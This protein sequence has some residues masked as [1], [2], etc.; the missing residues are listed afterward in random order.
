MPCLPEAGRTYDKGEWLMDSVFQGLTG[1]IVLPGNPFYNEFRQ[2]WNRAIQ[3]YPVVIDYCQSEADVSNA[4]LWARK[5]GVPIRIRSG[6]HNYE[7]YSNGNCTLVIDISEMNAMELDECEGI[8]RVQAGVTNGQVY[9]FVSSKGYPFPGGTCPTVGVSGFASGGGWGLSC[10]MFGLGCDSLLEIRMVNF[11]G[12]VLIANRMCNPDLFWALRG[13]GGG[14]FGVITGMVFRLPPKVDRVTLIEID[15]LHVSSQEQVQFLQTWQHWLA[16]ADNRMTLIARI[17]NSPSDGLAMLVRGIFYGEPEEAKRILKC[18][19]ALENAEPNLEYVS[20]LEAVTVIGSSYPPFEKFQS[21]SRYALR[22]LTVME[23]ESLAEIVSRPPRGSVF[24]GV[25]LY[26]LGG[27]VAEVGVNDTAFFYRRAGY[28]LWLET[29]WENSR[30]AQENR[31]WINLWFPCF[32]SMTT[33]SYVN[34]PYDLLSCYLEEYY[35]EHAPVLRKIKAKYDPLNVFTF[36]QGIDRYGKA[37]RFFKEDGAFDEESGLM[38]NGTDA[39]N[40][41]GFRYVKRQD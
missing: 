37:R 26:A 29:V 39:F 1:R 33:G 10:R 15:Y 7:G 13:A 25:S 3:Q 35:G 12:R 17:Y 18:F 40:H 27:R 9:G 14:N 6:G 11:E 19:L 4:V 32:A 2:G 5:H 22:E 21:V 31:D 16:S 24:A 36:P 28:I 34:F 41:R 23:C 38:E 20:F 30:F 8:L